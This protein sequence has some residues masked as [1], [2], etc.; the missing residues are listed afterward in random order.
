M[1]TDSPEIPRLET[2]WEG[3]EEASVGIHRKQNLYYA[4]R[5][6]LKYTQWRG[7]GR[8]ISLG[9]TVSKFGG[10]P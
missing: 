8:G 9:Y 1:L 4:W 5:D 2:W 10:Q 3:F 6:A 7:R